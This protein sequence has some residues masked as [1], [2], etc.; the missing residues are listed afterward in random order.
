VTSLPGN[1][2][3]NNSSI[4]QEASNSLT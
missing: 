4:E 1:K 3:E 2:M